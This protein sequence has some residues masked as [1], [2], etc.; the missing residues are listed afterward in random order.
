LSA[1]SYGNSAHL[2]AGCRPPGGPVSI[3]KAY[4]GRYDGLAESVSVLIDVHGHIGPSTPGVAPPGEVS[5]YADICGLD[6]V[7]VSNRDAASEPF[8]AANVDEAD[9]NLA[10]LVVCKSLKHLAAS[11]WVRPGRVDSHVLC[12]V[13][14]L[15]SEPFVAV[16]FSPATGGFDA[17]DAVLDP[18]LAA[19]SKLGRPAL[20]CVSADQRASPTKVYQTARRHPDVPVIL[21]I[22]DGATAQLAVAIEVVREALGRQDANLYLDTSYATATEIRQAVDAVGPERVVYG[23]DALSYGARHPD[24]QRQLLDALRNSLPPEQFG[25]VAGGN[26][27]RLLGLIKENR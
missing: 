9:A 13:G 22:C 3:R 20:F 19:L 24:R 8:T 26:A 23:S 5:R 17:S 6:L 16:T 12:M 25:Q 1:H 11:Y 4:R 18:Y 2:A 14:A 21:C 10:G 27:A 7:V 15:E